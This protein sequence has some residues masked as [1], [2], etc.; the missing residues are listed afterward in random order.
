[1]NLTFK[2]HNYHTVM[3]SRYPGVENWPSLIAFSGAAGAGKSTAA[4]ILQDLAS[5]SRVRFADP[6]KV[7]LRDFGL[8][9]EQVDGSLKETPCDL[10]CGKSPR[11]AM[12]T[13]GDEWGRQ[14]IGGDV[15]VRA[16]ERRIEEVVALRDCGIVVDDLR[17]PNE[18]D[19]ILA[20]GGVVIR[21]VRA[22]AGEIEAH[23]S[24]SHILFSQRIL[25]ND[26]THEELG[27]K[28]IRILDGLSDQKK[29]TA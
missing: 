16:W 11:R 3:T 20:R 15:W 14:L 5:Y 13:L 7:M 12:Q 28:L 27:D 29:M 23:A 10:L 25:I 26:G 6:I 19:A 8:T 1:M 18:L 9:F 22:E 24:E 17:Y 21:V 2:P 4:G